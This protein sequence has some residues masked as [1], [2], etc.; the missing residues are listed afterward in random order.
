MLKK[1]KEAERKM[2]LTWYGHSCFKLESAQGSVVFDPYEP[3][4]VPGLALPEGLSADAVICSH[5]HGD[6]GY[7]AGV[8]LTGR[9]AGFDVERVETFHDEAQGAKRGRNTVSIV[10]AEGLRIV[11]M[12]DIGHMPDARQC[13]ALM[14][15]DVVMIPVGGYYTINARTAWDIV[16]AIHPRTVIPMH[17]RGADFGFDVLAGV[18][19]FIALADNVRRFDTNVLTLPMEDTPVTAV[20]RCPVVR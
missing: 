19:E 7:A 18:E 2:T 9:E 11:H 6:H 15:A 8:K 13:A 16:R 5:A 3:G 1:A 17:Y 20:L 12:G 14:D 10:T 4:Y